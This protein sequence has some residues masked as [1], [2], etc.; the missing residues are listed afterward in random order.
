MKSH[1]TTSTFFAL[2]GS[3]FL[4]HA[5]TALITVSTADTS[6]PGSL[7]AA[8]SAASDGETIDFAP[9]LAGSTIVLGGQLVISRDLH[10]DASALTGGIT[11]DAN[12]TVTNQ[13]RA[14]QLNTGIDVTL[15]NLTFIRG[16]ETFGA[17]IRNTRGTLRM[18]DCTFTDNHASF[19]AG[20]I[21]S[22]NR[23]T[24]VNPAVL[25]LT[26]CTF[27]DNTSTDDGGALYLNGADGGLATA[28]IDSCTFTNNFSRDK[29]S[30]MYC[31]GSTGTVIVSIQNSTITENSSENSSGAAV[32]LDGN[33]RLGPSIATLELENNII[34]GNSASFSPDLFTATGEG[35]LTV[36]L[37]GE[38]L[39]S[40]LNGSDLTAGSVLLGAPLLAPLGDNGGPTQTRLPLPGSPAI[41]AATGST[42]TTDQR[43]LSITDGSPDIGATEFLP[44]NDLPLVWELDQDGDGF[45]FGVEHAL[46]SDP[47]D[48]VNEPCPIT[49]S[50]NALNQAVIEFTYNIE[51]IPET[52][53]ILERNFSLDP[54]QWQQVYLSSNPD[55][56]E[57]TELNP[58]INAATSV[59]LT[60]ITA[61]NPSPRVF[62]RFR[63]D[64][65]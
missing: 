20:A 31:S 48:S 14:M 60:D 26:N 23:S 29:G 35:D 57:V 28:T 54:T 39:L 33:S 40:S 49:L 22:E 58:L 43:G 37:V 32:Y 53:W 65:E 45:P 42:R 5:A 41:D 16:T 15:R 47:F 64:L 13:R 27:H 1:K 62:Y 11:I 6:G 9:G 56:G 18:F 51:A 34:A 44:A 52:V 21:Y 24:Q 50:F 8:V 3:L 30:A 46:G 55:D 4:T 2:F 25:E 61:P 17:A 38:N 12:G 10:I 7:A 36:T 63:A 19:V 59:E